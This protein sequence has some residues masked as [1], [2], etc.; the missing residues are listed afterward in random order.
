MSAHLQKV[1]SVSIA[2][3]GALPL[4]ADGNTFKPSGRK[5]DHVAGAK[6]SSGGFTQKNT[7]AELK[8]SLTAKKT[9]N[10]QELG[11]IEDEVITLK[12]SNGVVHVMSAAWV[13]EQ[14]ELGDDGKF[15]VKFISNE[16]EQM[17]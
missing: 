3:F 1:C 9:L 10:I 4:A 13:E 6:P 2:G 5:R 7:P 14:P 16:S 12:T 11:W 8:V 17:S 15:E